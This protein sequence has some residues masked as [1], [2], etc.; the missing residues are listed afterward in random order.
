MTCAMLLS[1]HA[2]VRYMQ[3]VR[4][5]DL[6]ELQ[7][8]AR[9]ISS[10]RYEMVSGLEMLMM[11]TRNAQGDMPILARHSACQAVFEVKEGWLRPMPMPDVWAL[12]SDIASV[13]KYKGKTN[14]RFTQMMIN[15]AMYSG[16]GQFS[17]DDA[18]KRV[19]D[20]LCGRGTT[21]FQALR[22][23]YDADGIEADKKDVQELNAYISRYFEYHKLKYGKK[24]SSMT[25]NGKAAGDRTSYTVGD[26]H[27]GIIQA[28]TL[29]AASF[30][31]PSSFDAL[32]ADLPYGIQHSSLDGKKRSNID[33]L[34][35]RALPV[36][37][38]LLKKGSTAVFSFNVFGISRNN[39]RDMMA[40]AGFTPLTGGPYDGMCHWVEQAV[41]RDVVVGLRV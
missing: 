18:A 1:P 15:I 13:L 10:V 2:N 23:G 11:E 38:S 36:W 26:L 28:N 27:L 34:M 14:E 32:I 35:R 4:D 9:E 7:I 21:L 12:A 20:P 31:K 37:H 6:C 5:L 17:A 39:L 3:S 25:A 30:Y 24:K 8:M 19:L 22:M 33:E 40:Q 16:M 29:D 41:T